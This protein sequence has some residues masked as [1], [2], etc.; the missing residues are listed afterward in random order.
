MLSV[1]LIL[2][3][4]LLYQ[5]DLPTRQHKIN[6][7]KSIPLV[8]IGMGLII[9]GF[10]AVRIFTAGNPTPENF[11]VP[12]VVNFPAPEL[13]LNDLKG[14]QINIAD[15]RQQIVLINN[16]ATWC[17]PCKA[18]MPT[19]LSYFKAHSDQ[20]F[21]LIGIE[22]GDSSE[23]VAKFVADIGLTFPILLDP[24][25]KSLIAFHNDS[26]PSSYVIDHN[27]NVVLAWTGPINRAM[28]EKYLTPLLEQ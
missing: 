26:L 20:G 2:V 21:M 17:P 24:N 4:F 18:E 14:K 3:P 10:V 23:D 9:L 25:K 13:T 12:S 19:L 11:V 22:A 1:S 28:L 15:Y 5:M 7:G 8:I 6:L 16:W 27:G